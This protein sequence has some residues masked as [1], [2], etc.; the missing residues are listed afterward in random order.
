MQSERVYQANVAYNIKM[1]EKRTDTSAEFS[2]THHTTHNSDHVTVTNEAYGITS[3]E[4]H[5]TLCTTDKEHTFKHTMDSSV[6]ADKAHNADD[7]SVTPNEAYGVT[8]AGTHYMTLCTT[9]K[10]HTYN[11]TM[12][13]SV[14]GDTENDSTEYYSYVR[15]KHY[16]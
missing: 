13:S 16:S 7:V 9:D 6:F 12:G 2:S 10:E 11:H 14:L 15:C 4:T 1:S 8:S 3:S 5:M